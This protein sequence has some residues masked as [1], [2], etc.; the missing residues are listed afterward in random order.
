MFSIKIRAPASQP[1]FLKKNNFHYSKD[2]NIA[3]EV[4]KMAL[5]IG[6]QFH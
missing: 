6:K 5:D 4:I 2:T 1:L 3:Y